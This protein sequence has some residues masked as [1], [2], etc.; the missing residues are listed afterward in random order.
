VRE[1]LVHCPHCRHIL[2]Q[3]CSG[4]RP[5]VVVVH[6]SE[7]LRDLIRRGA[8]RPSPGRCPAVT[9]YHDPCFLGRYHSG[10]GPVREILGSVCGGG[11]AEP[12]HT[13]ERSFCCGAGGGH[14]FMDLDRE[15]RPASRR[16]K[17]FIAC[18]AGTVAVSCPFC[19]AMLDDACRR[20]PAGEEPRVADWLELLR[21]SV[22]PP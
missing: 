14:F 21:E 4:M 5:P 18:G 22:E 13:R 8:L 2:E 20:L 9:A 1:I 3:I 15:E 11:L 19:H 6:T 17:E 16:V 12:E 10:Y 7:L